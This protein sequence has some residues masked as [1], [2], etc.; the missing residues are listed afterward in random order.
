MALIVAPA[1]GYD[2]L[3]SLADANAYCADMGHAG[4]TDADEAR[5][6]A[7]RRA[8]QYLLTRAARPPCVRCRGH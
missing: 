8:T 7:L 4:W 3:V 2:S 6:A 5:E 1:E